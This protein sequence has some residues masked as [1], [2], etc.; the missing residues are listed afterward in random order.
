MLIKAT[1]GRIHYYNSTPIYT[2]WLQPP[3]PPAHPQP[4]SPSHTIT[5]KM[6]V[7]VQANGSPPVNR[8]HIG[9]ETTPLR[10]RPPMC[11]GL[12]AYP[13][14]KQTLCLK[15]LWKHL[16]CKV[17]ECTLQRIT[18]LSFYYVINT[19]FNIMLGIF[20]CRI[21]LSPYFC[22]QY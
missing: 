4:S 10:N 18:S 21:L 9:I 16:N 15:P 1:S 5:P 13:C 12:A 19:R 6:R 11:I 7:G 8:K 14:V 20:C 17:S 22:A 2:V 3:P